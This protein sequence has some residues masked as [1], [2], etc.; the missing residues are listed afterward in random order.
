MELSLVLCLPH[1]ELS[2]PL[3][4]HIVRSA[5]REVGVETGCVADVELA[6]SEACTNVLDHSGPG[7]RYDVHLE[8]DEAAC[9]LRVVDVGHGFDFRRL[10]EDARAAPD[11]ERG[12]GLQLMRALVD[13]VRFNS[14]P[15]DGTIVRLEKALV[16]ADPSG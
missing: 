1:D 6:L 14:R 8:L 5:M 11:D 10:L 12:R 3:A 9:M 16:Y 4:R 2:V 15:E 13:T 7:D